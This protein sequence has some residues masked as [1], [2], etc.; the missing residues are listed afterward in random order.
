VI[1]YEFL[2]HVIILSSIFSITVNI[3]G[4]DGSFMTSTLVIGF[5]TLPPLRSTNNGHVV[6]VS[7]SLNLR[8]FFAW[9]Y[10]IGVYSGWHQ[11]NVRVCKGVAHHNIV[12]HITSSVDT[13]S[14]LGWL[15]DMI[16][17][18]GNVIMRESSEMGE[19]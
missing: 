2:Y 12:D 8:S 13:K 4:S 6:P 9:T 1:V 19:V 5:L 15:F 3:E 11:W 18:E 17:R 14:Y 16:L 7:N 10:R